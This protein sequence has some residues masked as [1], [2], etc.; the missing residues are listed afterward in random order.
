MY[1]ALAEGDS[2]ALFGRVWTPD[3]GQNGYRL[4]R[5]AGERDWRDLLGLMAAYRALHRGAMA[6]NMDLWKAA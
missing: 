6:E 5:T 2:S 3:P 1:R 4:W